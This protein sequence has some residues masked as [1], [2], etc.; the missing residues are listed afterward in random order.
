VPLPTKW[1]IDFGRPIPTDHYGPDAA[2]NLVLISQLTD[3]VR[4]IV[5]E[6][7]YERLEQRRSV[8]LG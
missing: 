2:E 1:F 6:M 4:N 3:Q 7:L 5:Q 8:F